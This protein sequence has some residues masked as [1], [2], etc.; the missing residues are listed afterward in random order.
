MYPELL[1]RIYKYIRNSYTGYII[2]G[3]IAYRIYRRTFLRKKRRK[4]PDEQTE[5]RR[6]EWAVIALLTVPQQVGIDGRDN[7]YVAHVRAY[8]LYS[9]DRILM[10]CVVHRLCSRLTYRIAA[11]HQPEGSPERPRLNSRGLRY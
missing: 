4:Y 3:I 10:A 1:K 11:E 9:S 6:R 5:V 7:A 8:V 2:G